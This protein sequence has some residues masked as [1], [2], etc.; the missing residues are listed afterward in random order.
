[1]GRT[2]ANNIMTE[3]F[4][5]ST[6][7]ETND[8]LSKGAVVAMGIS[9]GKDSSVLVLALQKFLDKI[10]HPREKRVLIHSDLGLIE[11]PESMEWCEILAARTGLE[12]IVVSRKAG[13]LLERWESRWEANWN[14]YLGLESLKVILPWSTASMRFCTSEL[15]T[16]IICRELRKRFPTEPILSATGIRAQESHARAKAP[17][18]SAQTKLTTKKVAG[19]NWNPI[20]SWTLDE[21]MEFHKT[22]DFPLHPAYTVYGASRVSCSQCMLATTKDQSA[23]L[24]NPG[25]HEAYKRL[26]ALELKSAFAFQQKRWLCDLNPELREQLLPGSGELLAKAKEIFTQ[27][28]VLEKTLP[29]SAFFIAGKPWPQAEISEEDAKQITLVRNS[30]LNLYGLPSKETPEEIREK[31]NARVA[32]NREKGETPAPAGPDITVEVQTQILFG[33]PDFQLD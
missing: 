7:P 25:N 9:G 27:R 21:V 31:I 10:G 6:T 13:G 23:A 19:F 17:V 15:K 22:E 5:I 32:A 24:G 4:A 14:R 16:A 29:K 2:G 8:L 33:T 30:V 12:L 26:C 11:W 3:R 20:L 1:M 28:E 18:M